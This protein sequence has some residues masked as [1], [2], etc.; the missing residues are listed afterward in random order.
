[1]QSP[2]K[3]V[4]FSLSLFFFSSTVIAQQKTGYVNFN[5]GETTLKT[6]KN[7]PIT[8]YGCNTSI[9]T[10]SK[11][12]KGPKSFK[13][14]KANQ[15]ISGIPFGYQ[16][17]S[18]NGEP[19]HISK[20]YIASPPLIKLANANDSINNPNTLYDIGIITPDEFVFNGEKPVQM[21]YLDYNILKTMHIK[22][23]KVEM[24]HSFER[25]DIDLIP[26]KVECNNF[27]W[28][29]KKGIDITDAKGASGIGEI[30]RDSTNISRLFLPYYYENDTN[31][32]QKPENSKKYVNCK[33]TILND[34]LFHH[35]IFFMVDGKK[36][37]SINLKDYY[38]NHG[39]RTITLHAEYRKELPSGCRKPDSKYSYKD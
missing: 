8:L 18:K 26:F 16:K 15:I 24:G 4:V 23:L 39:D 28:I 21:V 35:E 20:Y 5:L 17:D 12:W 34:I 22:Y 37:K 30:K 1:M 13:W 3:L 33:V 27:P 14:N 19:Y 25:L 31:S 6:K 11:Y 32:S 10:N 2:T 36:R 38:Y 9:T 29:D 7:H